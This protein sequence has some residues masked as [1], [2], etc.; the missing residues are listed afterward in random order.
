MCEYLVILEILDTTDDLLAGPHGHTGCLTAKTEGGATQNFNNVNH[1]CTLEQ[2]VAYP[3]LKSVTHS[4][5]K[6]K[7]TLTL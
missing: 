5:S 7:S 2:V 3:V 1:L 4:M 6:K